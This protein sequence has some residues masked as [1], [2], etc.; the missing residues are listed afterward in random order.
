MSLFLMWAGVAKDVCLIECTYFP[1]VHL[2]RYWYFCGDDWGSL[3][4]V[5]NTGD[6][7]GSLLIVQSC[8]G[9]NW[10]VCLQY[11]A[12]LELTRDVCLQYTVVL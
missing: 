10:E 7:W 9:D 12:V 5:Q 2:S 1:K 4:I 6:D 11:Q 8:T 3:L